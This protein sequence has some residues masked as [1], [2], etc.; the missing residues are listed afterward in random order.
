M[1]HPILH[2]E[3]QEFINNSLEANFAKIALTKNPFPELAWT[4]ILTQIGS[5][6]KAKEKLPHWF[7][8]KNIIY[9]SKL[10]I[11]QTSSETTAQYKS[12]I[13]N[14][15]TLIDLTG[16]FGIDDFYF[17]KKVNRVIHCEYKSDLSEIVA[18]NYEVLGCK[19]IECIA[20]DSSEI[21]QK[22]NQKFD[23]IYIDPS[24]RNDA[25]GKVF[26]LRDCLPNVPDNL[27]NYFNYTD[28]ILIKTA[29]I[30]DISAGLNELNS[31][32]EIHIV[33][34]QNEV[35]E[36]LWILQKGAQKAILIK[37]INFGI[38]ETQSFDFELNIE[39]KGIEIGFPEKYLYE[40]N[41]AIMKSGGFDSLSEKY[42]I[43]KL[44]THSHLFT[45]NDLITFPGRVFE[46]QSVLD[47]TKPNMKRYCTNTKMNVSTR[48]FPESVEEIRK[49]WKIKDGGDVYSFFTTNRD[50]HK[51]MLLCA[52]IN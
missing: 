41:S 11:E 34:V 6:K 27:S 38:S 12:E 30:L 20:G 51:I 19:N 24:R 22:L 43:K 32:T 10:S 1:S 31:V 15:T 40:P 28:N 5:K 26:M 16:G 7:A 8:N 52:K 18:H 14:G 47:Y 13:I 2:P 42:P 29:P 25:K 44:H 35:K 21:L 3:V 4:D 49:K 50:N 23:W 45:S 9:P 17:A 36:L 33:A 39:K 48:N 46:I 37:T